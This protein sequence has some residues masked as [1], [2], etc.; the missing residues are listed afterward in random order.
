MWALGE[1]VF[2]ALTKVPCFKKQYEFSQYA[3][4]NLEFPSQP[5]SNHTVDGK[6]QEFVQGLMK[7]IPSH[8]LKV[9]EALEHSWVALIEVHERSSSISSEENVEE[10]VEI[11]TILPVSR[12]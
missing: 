1:V 7:P 5:L 3:I 2:Q 8:R 6:A 12:H 4:G 11:I 9:E 10:Y